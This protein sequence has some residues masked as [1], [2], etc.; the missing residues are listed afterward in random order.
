M[1]RNEVKETEE[2]EVGKAPGIDGITVML[3]Y[4]VVVVWMDESMIIFY[5]NQDFNNHIPKTYTK[6]TIVLLC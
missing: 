1:A 6:A 2:I 4:D 5:T 3:K